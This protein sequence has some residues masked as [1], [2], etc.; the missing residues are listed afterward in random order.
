MPAFRA[1]QQEILVLRSWDFGTNMYPLVEIVKEYDRARKPESQRSFEE[2]HNDLIRDIKAERVFIDLPVYLKVTGAVQVEVVDFSL[3]ILNNLEKRCEYLLKLRDHSPKVIPVVSSY[4]LKTGETGTI[5]KQ[6]EIISPYFKTIAYRLFPQT[7]SIDFPIVKELVRDNDFLIMD[8]DQI[9]PYPKS[10]PLRPIVSALKEFTGCFKILLR[11]AINTEIQ[12]VKL[13]HGQVVFDADNSHIETDI[14]HDFGVNATGDYVGIK[15][16]DLTA[17]GTI[18]PGFLYYDAVEN[19]YYGYRAD[20]KELSQFEHKIVP[21]ILDSDSTSRMLTNVP[22]YVGEEN[23][24]YA[25][26]VNIRNGEESGKSQAKFKRIAMEH[27]LYCMMT[28]IQS[29]KLRQTNI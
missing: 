1:R 2:I 11:S 26:L 25:T 3:T 7:F 20:I 22:T 28:N 16:D 23:P 29:Q 18:S 21:D 27:Y 6:N 24:G 4:M 9:P 13:E 5:E 8:L 19:Q 15:K 14:M 10:P 17:G 12:N